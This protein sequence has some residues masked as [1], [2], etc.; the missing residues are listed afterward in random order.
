MKENLFEAYA[1]MCR[2][3]RD[4]RDGCRMH[5]EGVLL[6]LS[7]R[8]FIEEYPDKAKEIVEKWA[9]EHP[10]KTRQDAYL[11]LFPNALMDED[12]ILTVRPCFADKKMYYTCKKTK[13]MVINTS[14]SV[15]YAKKKFWKTE[16]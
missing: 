8:T 3:Y 7:C 16:V 2:S 11:Q 13:Y 15:K 14:Q 5:E 12:G 9:E 6:K 4:C 10:I 1:R